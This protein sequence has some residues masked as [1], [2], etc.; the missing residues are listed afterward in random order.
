V[1]ILLDAQ[2]ALLTP[3]TAAGDTTDDEN[4]ITCIKLCSFILDPSYEDQ[5]IY[6]GLMVHRSHDA[7]GLCADDQVTFDHIVSQNDN[8]FGQGDYEEFE[9]TMAVVA[10]L[11]SALTKAQAMAAALA[12]DAAAAG[13]TAGADA[14]VEAASEEGE[15]AAQVEAASEE[16]KSD[17]HASVATN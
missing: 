16:G 5:V 1:R 7:E 15:S 12:G 13:A 6:H 2:R 3:T 11:T 9:M 14:Q 4:R 8:Q 10:E 17:A